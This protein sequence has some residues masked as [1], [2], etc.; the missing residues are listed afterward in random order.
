MTANMFGIIVSGR[1]VS[2]ATHDM[3]IGSIVCLFRFRPTSL[4]ST[5]I[6]SWLPFKTLMTLIMWSS[7][8][9]ERNPFPKEW[10][11]RVWKSTS[12]SMLNNCFKFIPKYTS[13]FP[14]HYHRRRGSTWAS[15]LMRNL[16]PYS[17]SQN[18]NKRTV[19]LKITVTV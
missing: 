11:V 18:S 7:S 16:Q 8:W 13:V 3:S 14:T 2:I 4:G 5:S 9:P 10:V 12:V 15:Y 6:S 17:R 19:C 1:L